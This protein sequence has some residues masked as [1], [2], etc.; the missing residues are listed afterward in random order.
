[1]VESQPH[2]IFKQTTTTNM[3]NEEF[4]G[5]GNL[6]DQ[7][8]TEEEDTGAAAAEEV[9]NETEE[10]VLQQT[11]QEEETSGNDYDVDSS[12]EE[13]GDDGSESG[14]DSEEETSEEGEEPNTVYEVLKAKTGYEVEGEFEEDLD[15]LV[16]YV[17]KLSE[18][19]AKEELDAILGNLPE[20]KQFIEF[21]QSGGTPEQYFQVQHPDND[22]DK[23]QLSEDNAQQQKAVIKHYL[24]RR[25]VDE[26]AADNLIQV[27][28]D[29]EKLLP[30]AKKFLSELRKEQ[31][32]QKQAQLEA[33]RQYQAQQEEEQ[34]AYW[35]EVEQTVNS[36]DLGGFSIPQRR[37]KE[38]ME[39]MTKPVD[40]AGNTQR[41]LD[42]QKLDMNKMLQ[43]E[44]MVYKG[45]DLKDEVQKGAARKKADDAL[46]KITS[47]KSN[48]MKGGSSESGDA[49]GAGAHVKSINEIL[50]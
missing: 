12:S 16:S 26:D 42:A 34:K 38:F 33:Q 36:G 28:E 21:L 2:T 43:L 29:S 31:N 18:I 23:I 1:M 9:L 44:Y 40:R 22:Y 45:F 13:E 5:L 46:K 4:L 20:A 10:D 19:K 25:G 11:D 47:R 8:V 14:S 37:R 49:G 32:E 3:E 15:G 7:P 48:K 41:M 17:D 39:W 24:E 27:Y 35:A 30:N 6:L 50:G